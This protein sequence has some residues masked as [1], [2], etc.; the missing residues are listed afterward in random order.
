MEGERQ[1]ETRLEEEIEVCS[2]EGEIITLF[3]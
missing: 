2:A 1:R 3:Q